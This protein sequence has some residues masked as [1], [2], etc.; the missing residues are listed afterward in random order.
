MFSEAAF[1]LCHYIYCWICLRY[2]SNSYL[3]TYF[4][5]SIKQCVLL[6]LFVTPDVLLFTLTTLFAEPRVGDAQAERMEEEA[7]SHTNRRHVYSFLAGTAAVAADVTQHS[8]TQPPSWLTQ[9]P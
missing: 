1:I 5:C 2:S 9:W 6:I 7:R 8:L 3:Y 4:I